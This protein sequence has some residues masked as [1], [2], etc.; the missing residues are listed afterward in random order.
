MVKPTIARKK[1][2]QVG[3]VYAAHLDRQQLK[4]SERANMAFADRQSGAMLRPMIPVDIPFL[5]RVFLKTVQ[6]VPLHYSSLNSVAAYILVCDED[7]EAVGWYGSECSLEDRKYATELGL[8]V[9]RLDLRKI[10]ATHFPF[11]SEANENFR[12]LR[13]ILPKLW[14]DEATY[15]N[16]KAVDARR[17]PIYNAP[18]SIGCMDK[19]L[20]G[21][22]GLREVAFSSSDEAGTVP[23]LAFVPIELNTVAVLNYAD[24]WDV[25]IARG[26]TAADEKA[27]L[28]YIMRLSA[29]RS[30]NGL[31]SAMAT[32]A[33]N[34]NVRITRQG[35]ERILFRETIRMLTDFEPPGKTVAWTLPQPGMSGP[36]MMSMVGDSL[37]DSVDALGRL[38]GAVGDALSFDTAGR[39]MDGLMGAFSLGGG[40]GGDIEEKDKAMAAGGGAA[41]AWPPHP[42]S[43]AELKNSGVAGAGAALGGKGDTAQSA[44]AAATSRLS[45]ARFFSRSS[46]APPAASAIDAEAAEATK[47]S[48]PA[49]P[50][51]NKA[52]QSKTRGAFAGRDMLS[53][54]MM[55][56]HDALSVGA[57]QSRAII[58]TVAYEPVILVGYQVEIDEGPY[59]GRYV[60]TGV[61]KS[62][63][64]KSLFRL[65]NF[66]GEDEWVKLKRGN[67][68]GLPFRVLRRVFEPN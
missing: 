68:A 44:S 17:K 23:R 6:R 4:P 63:F 66:E 40:A 28:D 36:G 45:M 47:A 31:L 12:I 41:G 25:W 3:E 51:P 21:S 61:K 67:K 57:S 32:V 34:P 52:I 65:S 37:G 59:A 15:R 60:V 22:V 24:Q 56:F 49:L 33:K 2:R 5:Y 55:D 38:G 14:G 42:P 19:Y 54:D 30:G 13:Y 29:S 7:R 9:L 46:A 20:D 43:A 8:Q 18:V 11:N 50:P 62:V 35:C 64:Q 27:V 58:D 26:V 1:K 39:A 48:G 16:K 10:A 53:H